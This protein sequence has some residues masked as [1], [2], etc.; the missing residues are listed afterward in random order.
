M[1]PLDLTLPHFHDS[2]K[3]NPIAHL[4]QLDDYFRLKAVPPQFH[5]AIALRSVTDL[6]TVEWI[7]TVSQTIS[8]YE[9]F[10]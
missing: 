2:E 4:R 7:A 6:L 8:N 5:L 3:V 10:K 9:E 1:A